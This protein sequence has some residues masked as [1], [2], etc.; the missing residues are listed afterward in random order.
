MRLKLI[1][2]SLLVLALVPHAFAYGVL[3]H[4]ELIDVAWDNTIRPAL[5]K[6]FPAASEDELKRAH[7]YAYGGSVI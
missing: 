4:E 3:S 5:L 7:A 1:L 2:L 6:R